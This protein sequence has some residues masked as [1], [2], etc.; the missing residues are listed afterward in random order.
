MRRPLPDRLEVAHP[1][2]ARIGARIALLLPTPLRRRVI[3]GAFSRAEAAFNRHDLAPTLAGWADDVVYEP[4]PPLPGARRLV[5]RQAVAAFWDATFERFPDSRI[6]NLDV[7]EASPGVIRRTARLRHVERDTG[8]TLKYT[9]LQITRLRAGTVV[10]Q[11]NELL[12]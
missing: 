4:P 9:I 7:Q 8:R 2:L 1:A 10:E 6:E 3:A 12:D 11:T 5:G